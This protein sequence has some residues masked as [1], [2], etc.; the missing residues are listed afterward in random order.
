MP[1]ALYLI[2]RAFRLTIQTECL[3]L[4]ALYVN[5]VLEPCVQES[6]CAQNMGLKSLPLLPLHFIIFENVKLS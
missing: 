5:K 1:N 2:Y 6:V 4:W 3:S